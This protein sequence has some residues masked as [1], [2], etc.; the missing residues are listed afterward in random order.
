MSVTPISQGTEQPTDDTLTW[1]QQRQQ[2]ELEKLKVERDIKLVELDIANAKRDRAKKLVRNKQV[3]L[4]SSL[5]IALFICIT[6][7]VYFGY[8]FPG[9]P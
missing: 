5:A 9:T 8:F 1:E 7:G 4:Y 6:V 3:E 2:L